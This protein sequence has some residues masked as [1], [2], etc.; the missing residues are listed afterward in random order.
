MQTSSYRLR[1][2][3][4]FFVVLNDARFEVHQRF[5]TLILDEDHKHLSHALAVLLA[6]RS[7]RWRP[8]FWAAAAWGREHWTFR[9]TTGGRRAIPDISQLP[10]Q[11]LSRLTKL[12]TALASSPPL[13][14][15]DAMQD[16]GH[17][18]LDHIVLK[19]LGLDE[20]LLA[21]VHEELR[22]LTTSR[23]AKALVYEIWAIYSGPSHSL[24]TPK[25][26]STGK[27]IL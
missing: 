4:V 25:E 2:M 17:K 24:P 11:D 13:H 3:T 21:T 20:G 10:R 5:A 23:L 19:V 27:F 7:S 9:R 15:A 22:R 8:R 14:L 6:A 1:S 12:W 16:E 26:R 18:Q